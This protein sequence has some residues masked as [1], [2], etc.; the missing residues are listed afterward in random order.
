MAFACVLLLSASALAQQASGIAGLVRDASGGVLPG[1]T[2]E[3][4]S[5]ALIE[6]VR[7]VV[8]DGEGRYNIVDLRPGTYTVTFT[9]AGFTTFRREGIVLTSGFTATVNADMQVGALEETITVTQEAPLVDTQNVRR[10]TVVSNDLLDALPTSTKHWG[11]VVA[12][13]PGFTGI[14]DVA[15]QLDQSLGAAFH[16]KTGSKRQFDGMSIDHASGNQG[17]IPNSA[18][19]E[20]TSVQ[21]SGISAESNA[22]GAV[23]N[24]I[25][26]EGSNTFRG[27]LFGLWTGEQ[28]ASD[29]LTD[30]LRARGLTTTS[31]ILKI[32]DGTFTLGGPIVRD[33][34]WFFLAPREW[35]SRN[36]MAGM[37]W[38][39]TQGTPFWTPDPTRPADRYQWYSSRAFRVTWQA[40]TVNKFNVFIDHA[41]ACIC[42]ALGAV[43]QPPE[44][45][46]AFHFR[47]EGLYQATWSA[48]VTK[49]VLL[50]AG[51]S[52]AILSFPNFLA[53]GVEPQHISILEQSTGILYTARMN[54]GTNQNDR[55]A[56]RFS[57]A[58]V[59]GS[60]AIKAGFQNEEAIANNLTTVTGGNVNYR[61]NNGVPNQITQYATPYLIANRIRADMGL[62]A[63][64]QWAIRRLTLNYGVRFDYFTG[65]VPAQH[66]DA[67]P[68][69]WVPERSFAEVTGVPSWKDWSPR[70]G[71]AYDLFGEGRTALKVSV[72]RYVAKTG[73]S[74][75]NANNPIQTSVNSVTRTW[76]D[77][78]GNYVPDCDL[79]NR[80]ANGECAAVSDQN[81]GGLRTNTRYADDVIHGWGVRGYNWD[82]ATEVQHQI[83]RG[84]SVT[85]G[86]YRNW[87]GNFTVTDNL[88]VSPSDYTPYC[89]TAPIDARLPGGGGYQVCDLYD[90]SLAKFGSSN[91]LVTQASNYGKQKQVDDFFNAS[92]NTRLGSGIQFGGGVDT[93][94]TVVDACLTVDSPG[95]VLP[96]VPGASGSAAPVPFNATT[97]AGKRLCRVVTPFKG[98]T[99]LKL[100][101]SY[102][103]PGDFV[104]GGVFQNM[105]G[106]DIEADYAATTTEIAPSLGRNLASCGTR[107]PCTATVTV[108]LIVPQT[109]F[110][111]RITRLDLRVTKRL[112]LPRR[113][114]LLA[115]V[116]VYNTL[117]G[118]SILQLAAGT[119]GS[120]GRGG[121]TYGPRWLLPSLV[122]EG[123]IVQF[124]A[125]LSF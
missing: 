73:T 117:N 96:N 78:N 89:I 99:Q 21:T 87:F 83:G 8:S 103:L 15:G 64:D 97:I 107:V 75:T 7:T 100:F 17:Y 49:R 115:N 34:L 39:K 57:V 77:G 19:V 43:G 108:P 63:Q 67:T 20:E 98:Q 2:V 42:R 13:T 1:V 58:Y 81:F 54:Y 46:N 124:S 93:G 106:P 95:A 36:Q 76:T 48:P 24:M 31:K 79:R 121:Y 5:A 56:Q 120:Q 45:G 25:P 50:D 94:R 23:V 60:H 65:Y 52:A 3:A 104:V 53:P 92:F 40:S 90:I 85:G 101:G 110:E 84:M 27:T 74:V 37:F 105:S 70:L 112:Q 82:V 18:T 91:N 12:L 122:L 9:L 118:S 119:A 114:R 62:Y 11:T 125:Q 55:Y 69:G 59:T 51:M 102:P 26:K 47:P 88:L 29:N 14:G 61:F 4:A 28:L 111:G 80:A 109:L 30:D 113:V 38:N 86:Y 72:G 71:A 33:R 35:G 32:Y 123:R 116:D 41:D 22:D 6:K 66:V 16:G 10:Q 44:T 68:N